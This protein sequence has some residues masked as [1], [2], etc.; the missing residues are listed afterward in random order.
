ML[1]ASWSD[2]SV[3]TNTKFVTLVI[4]TTQT[5]FVCTISGRCFIWLSLTPCRDRM[6]SLGPNLLIFSKMLT[7]TENDGLLPTALTI[8]ATMLPLPRAFTAAS[9]RTKVPGR[10][11][12][13]SCVE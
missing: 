6:P 9:S 10:R 2:A 1:E 3:N 7:S 12:A 8:L 5:S 13:L 11:S 4:S